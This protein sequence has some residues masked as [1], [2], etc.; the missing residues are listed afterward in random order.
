[1]RI[2]LL[3]KNG[4]LGWELQ[5]TLPLLGDVFA[6]DKEEIDFAKTHT[7]RETL[8]TSM[9][10]LIVNASAYTAVDQAEAER[11]IARKVNVEAPRVMAEEAK[12]RNALLIHFSTDYVFDGLS[13]KPYT[14]KDI[15]N[16]Q[17][18]Y[19]RTKL[20]GEQAIEEVG[21]RFFIFRTSWV[22]SLRAANFIT[23][24]IKLAHQQ[25]ELRA[26]TD[27]TGCPTWARMLADLTTHVIDKTTTLGL[28]W[29]SSRY[30]IYHLASQEYVSRYDMVCFIVQQLGLP[31]RVKP[32]LTQEFP[33]PAVRPPF[34][35]LS[36]SY[37]CEVF[38]L[39]VPAWHEMLRLALGNLSEGATK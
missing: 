29:T 15:P 5:R 19:G 27:Q 26:V 23:R 2:L 33:A 16:P 17:N 8:N 6:L 21:G 14:E 10:D 4:Q 3:G 22:Y 11:E 38:D 24:V 18:A 7:L 20:E 12:K 34:S 31:V 25:E 39:R 35:A 32:A 37:F 28:E 30:G 13:E 9:W 1:M 36:S